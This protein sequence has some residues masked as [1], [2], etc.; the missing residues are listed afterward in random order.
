MHSMI[1]YY[2]VL[3]AIAF[4]SQLQLCLSRSDF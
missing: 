3:I 1:V 2:I 4:A